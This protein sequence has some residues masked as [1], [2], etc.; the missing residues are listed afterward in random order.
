MILF[1]FFFFSVGHPFFIILFHRF[2][3]K[4]D[5]QHCAHAYTTTQQEL[6]LAFVLWSLRSRKGWR[7]P[8][9]TVIV[10]RLPVG[11]QNWSPGICPGLSNITII[12]TTKCHSHH[13]SRKTK[14]AIGA[15][16]FSP[17]FTLFWV[18]LHSL[19]H[20]L[21]YPETNWARKKVT[22]SVNE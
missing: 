12:I 17:L 14:R 1:Y 4:P 19:L 7:G 11:R 18:P 6:P 13:R 22:K 5:G 9:H 15:T 10:C 20:R 21:P 8:H 16:K 3:F 2:L